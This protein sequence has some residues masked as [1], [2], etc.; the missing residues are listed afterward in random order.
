MYTS[1]RVNNFRGLRKTTLTGLERV[2]LI[3]GMNNVGKTALLEALFLHCGAYNPELTLRL[4]AFRGLEHVKLEFGRWAETPWDSLFSQFDTSNEV[5]LVGEDE[6]T[7][8]RVLRL[9]V[10]RQPE[11]LTKIWRSIQPS[12][13][14]PDKPT[15][16]PFFTSVTAQVLELK[17]EEG[18]Q[19]REYYMI[20]DQQG[21]RIEPFP[22]LPPF[23][24]FF[25]AARVRTSSVED[26][27]RFG[28]L[29]T[30]KS[31]DVLLETLQV[32]EPRLNQLTVV[33]AGG[34]PTIYGDIGLARLVPLPVM[35]EGMARLASLVLA[36]GNAPNGVVLVDEIENGFH[37]S[38]LPK[39]WKAIGEAARRFNTQVFAT[40]HSL[41]CIMAAHK[42]F[43][44]SERYDFRLYRLERVN[45]D[46]HAVNY[47]RE[48]LEAA[49]ETGLE[50]R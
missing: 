9:R 45:G 49:I 27:E 21:L 10:I 43:S 47:D 46:I 8:R 4:N 7:G 23:P 16:T 32:I 3:A 13:H 22:P 48:S 14:N 28:K 36:I 30:L 41:E 17:S 15:G 11:E 31:E 20:L 29:Q 39:V 34:I 6:Q 44:E 50:V 37:H 38:I 19:S 1:F 12:P 26:V 2:N 24:A 25:L 42:A 40:T 35:G 33:V 5:E 18:K